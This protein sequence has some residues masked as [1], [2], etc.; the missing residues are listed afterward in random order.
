MP[1]KDPTLWALIVAWMV[2]NW[3]AVYGALLALIIAF[4]RITYH[5][6]RGQQ[7]LIESLLCGFI[8]LAVATGVRLLGIPDD[9]TPFIGGVVGL[10]GVD[11][12]RSTAERLLAARHQQP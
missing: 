6:G 3:P 12:L 1:T 7:R 2:D 8:T 4:L 11:T 5:G 9:A 10:L